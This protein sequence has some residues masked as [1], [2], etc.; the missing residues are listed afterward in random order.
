MQPSGEA[1]HVE[2]DDTDEMNEKRCE[3]TLKKYTKACKDAKSTQNSDSF[4]IDDLTLQTFC[5]F[6]SQIIELLRHFYAQLQMSQIEKC[7]RII[8]VVDKKYREIRMLG[9]P[10]ISNL[11]QSLDPSIKQARSLLNGVS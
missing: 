9:S 5:E 3:I 11:C 8:E 2:M 7:I 4:E 6:Q 1:E 10:I